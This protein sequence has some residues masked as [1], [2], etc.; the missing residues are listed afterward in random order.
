[1]L[2]QLLKSKIH[3]AKVSDGN[4]DYEGSIT[5][6]R[7]LMDAVDLWAGEKVLVVSI[8]S[9]ARLETY[10]QEGVRG[11]GQVI[12]NGG[13]ARKIIKGDTVTIIA[14]GLSDQPITAKKVLC[15]DKNEI[16]RVTK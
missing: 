9:G 3:R 7:D 2:R 6:P 16:V 13:A 1:M 11:S 4:I 8:D 15:N 14:F 5:I 12:I 10:V